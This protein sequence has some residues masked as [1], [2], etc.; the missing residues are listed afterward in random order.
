MNYQFPNNFDITK[1]E[2]V[3]CSSCGANVYETVVTLKKIPGFIT[4]FADDSK[5]T[6]NP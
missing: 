4:K 2:D 5:P 3:S 1:A 6:A